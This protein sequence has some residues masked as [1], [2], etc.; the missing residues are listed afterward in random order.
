MCVVVSS[1]KNGGADVVAGLG[2]AIAVARVSRLKGI[3]F[4]LLFAVTT[5]VG[6]AIGLGI[7][8]SYSDDEVKALWV[9]G[10]LN[11][12]AAGILIYAGLVEMIVEDFSRCEQERP[13]K[14]V[15]MALAV[16]AGYG[17]MTFIAIWA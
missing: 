4:A 3:V 8:S 1:C 14:K 2:A 5:P 7:E 17:V 10:V 13:A 16:L 11:A 6:I 12:I 15:A 9:K